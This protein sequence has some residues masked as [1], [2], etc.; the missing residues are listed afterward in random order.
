[1]ADV[2]P[3]VEPDALDGLPGGPYDPVQ[4]NAGAEAV[5]RFAGWHIAP[6][7]ET[8]VLLDHDGSDRLR[9]PT[10]KLHEVASV[11]D[12]SSREPRLIT[13]WR[14][15]MQSAVL[16]GRFP[17]GIA[18]VEVVFSHGYDKCPDDLLPVI[19][20]ASLSGRIRSRQA[21]P[22][23]ETYEAGLDSHPT[24]AASI[25]SMYRLGPRP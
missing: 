24:S 22:F 3:L 25:L 17:R 13:G 11:T 9:L 20:E 5:R 14:A 4:V 10:L 19:A 8:T 1:M 15:S 23:Q 18:V 12:V 7:L 16:A 6:R 2:P 21:G